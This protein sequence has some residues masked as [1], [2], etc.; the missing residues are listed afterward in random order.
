MNRKRKLIIITLIVFAAVAALIVLPFLKINTYFTNSKSTVTT[1]EYFDVESEISPDPA[2]SEIAILRVTPIYKD[3][4]NNI[5]DRS[6]M[7]IYAT[8]GNVHLLEPV[9]LVDSSDFIFRVPTAGNHTS[10]LDLLLRF[11]IDSSNKI[12]EK[13]MLL[14]GLKKTRQYDWKVRL[15]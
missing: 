2:R 5:V 12:I 10:V 15:H 13:S 4:S 1:T 9:T 14:K 3:S 11:K 7:K 8:I 6:S